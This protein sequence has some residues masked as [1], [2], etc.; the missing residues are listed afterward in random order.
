MQK[1][2]HK[3]KNTIIK[4][5]IQSLSRLDYLNDT[6]FFFKRYLNIYKRKKQYNK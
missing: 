5:K 2:N 4:E 6:N 3:K 1:V